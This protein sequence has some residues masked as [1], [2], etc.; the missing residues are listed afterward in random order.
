MGSPAMSFLSAPTAGR[1][2]NT[3]SKAMKVTFTTTDHTHAK[4]GVNG[5]A[6]GGALG[7]YFVGLLVILHFGNAFCNSAI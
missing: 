5:G 7:G 4:A 2:N 3:A 6:A 1:H